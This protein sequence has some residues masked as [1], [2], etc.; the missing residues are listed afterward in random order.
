MSGGGKE[1]Q[2]CVEVLFNAGPEIQL[3]WKSILESFKWLKVCEDEAEELMKMKN[4]HTKLCCE[5]RTWCR[6][7]GVAV[8]TVAKLR[9]GGL[10]FAAAIPST[11]S[12]RLNWPRGIR[13]IT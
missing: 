13:P 5:V 1:E 11:L 7:R 2:R 6:P 3:G 4:F 8:A 12:R 9:D 10:E